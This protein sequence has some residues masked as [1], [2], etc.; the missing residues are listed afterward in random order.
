[1]LWQVAKMGGIMVW[2]VGVMHRYILTPIELKLIRTHKIPRWAFGID[3]WDT[4]LYPILDWM[5]RKTYLDEGEESAVKDDI[6]A[7]VYTLI[8]ILI[9][10]YAII[11]NGCKV[12]E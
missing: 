3:A 6:C 12:V 1:M 7:S 4:K 10:V 2:N 9:F 8:Q 11:R 5:Y